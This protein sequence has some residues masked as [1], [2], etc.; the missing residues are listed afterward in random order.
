MFNHIFI[1][2]IQISKH[3]MEFMNLYYLVLIKNQYNI[4]I[5]LLMYIIHSYYLI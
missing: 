1:Q 3:A 2:Y 4:I 5:K